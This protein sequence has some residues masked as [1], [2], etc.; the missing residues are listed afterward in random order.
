MKQ[1]S[2]SERARQ[3]LAFLRRRI[4]TGEW[5]VNSKIP[6]ETE[7]MS[8]LGVGKTTVREAV[9]SLASMGMLETLPG[10]GTFVRSRSP[11]STVLTDFLSDYTVA[12]ILLYRRALE[13]EAAQQAALH[14]TEADL[15]ALH[16]AHL[17]DGRRDVDYPAVERGRTPGQFHFLLLEATGSQLFQDL[18]AGVMAALRAAIDRGT[19]VFAATEDV[20]HDDHA[21]IL[22][23]VEA[24][25]VERAASAM[26]AHVGHD[27]IADLA[28]SP[29]HAEG[30]LPQ[31]GPDQTSREMSPSAMPP[32]Q[33][34]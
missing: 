16:A 26:A 34:A 20:R 13:I 23:A 9:R 19:V 33:H 32:R 8:M 24:R 30:L 14:R 29:P 17:Q 18:Y 1:S 15:V 7:L 5:P 6:I 28:G 21:R 4:A 25:D 31:Q 12:E 10:R 11:V 2:G 27:L 3:T 22:T